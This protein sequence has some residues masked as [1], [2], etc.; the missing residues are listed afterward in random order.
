V[1]REGNNSCFELILKHR[2]SRR[3]VHRNRGN[4]HRSSKAAEKV[5]RHQCI[6]ALV[7][8]TGRGVDKRKNHLDHQ[9]CGKINTNRVY[10]KRTSR[11]SRYGQRT[12]KR[13]LRLRCSDHS[14]Q[15]KTCSQCRLPPHHR[16]QADSQTP[17][18]KAAAPHKTR[19]VEGLVAT[20]EAQVVIM[21]IIIVPP[22]S[23]LAAMVLQP[24]PN[25]NRGTLVHPRGCI[26]EDNRGTLIHPRGCIREEHFTLV[27]PRGCIREEHLAFATSL[28]RL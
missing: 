12:T 26:R 19:A 23:I 8:A 14:C 24:H 18:T 17:S 7:L 16:A 4:K 6:A 11:L 1:L 5:E 10:H 2:N 27:H 3:Q 21:C 22:I 13:T 20:V 15:T 28:Y 25:D 9:R